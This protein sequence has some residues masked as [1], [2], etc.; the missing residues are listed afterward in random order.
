MHV[1]VQ[2]GREKYPLFITTQEHTMAVFTDDVSQADVD[3]KFPVE[4]NKSSMVNT[5][6]LATLYDEKIDALEQIEF[7]G[8]FFD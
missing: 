6:E 5:T 1:E 3:M 4:F 7:S 2:L 8:T